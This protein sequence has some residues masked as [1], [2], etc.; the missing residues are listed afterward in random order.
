M[1]RAFVAILFAAAA[2]VA[3]AP[4][5]APCDVKVVEKGVYCTKEERLIFA[6]NVKD[7]KCAN[8][9]A[10]ARDVEVCVKEHFV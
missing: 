8:D 2:A 7:G 9:Q 1:R 6:G 5:R 4:L 10:D 3:A